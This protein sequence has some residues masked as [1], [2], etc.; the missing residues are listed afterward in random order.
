MTTLRDMWDT[1]DSHE[2]GMNII[3]TSLLVAV[4]VLGLAEAGV[5]IAM[6]WA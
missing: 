4:G 3:G 5:A 1:K 6:F 2:Q